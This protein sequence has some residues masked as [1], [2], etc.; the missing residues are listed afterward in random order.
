MSDTPEISLRPSILG[1]IRG[2]FLTG[3]LVT[4]PIA[5]TLYLTWWFL[6][7]IDSQVRGIIPFESFLPPEYLPYAVPGLGIV[8]AVIAFVLI[9]WL[10]RN[11]MG[12][13]FIN[14]YE[15]VL[16]RLPVVNSLYSA[17]KQ[18][19]ETVMMD[20]S[21][22][23]KDV[24]MV[25]FPS[26]GMWSLGF[27]TGVTQG[28][29]QRLTEHEVVNVYVPTTPNPTSGFLLFIPKKDLIYISMSSEDAIKM[30]VS[31]GIITPADKS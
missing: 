13:I 1:H 28:E 4:A 25:Q 11:F 24:V 23:F 9:G 18:V 20:Q 6:N 5:I 27:V 17:T 21:R 8:I 31:G 22:A 30:I 19:F 15:Y 7:L 16:N 12:R 29:V 26:P 14:I 3:I 2:Y 10:A